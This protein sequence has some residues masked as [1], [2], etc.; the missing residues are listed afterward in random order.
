MTSLDAR[1]RA[2][3]YEIAERAAFAGN[4]DDYWR[5]AE[6]EIQDS[7]PA[8]LP[9][10]PVSPLQSNAVA[11]TFPVFPAVEA[12]SVRGLGEPL[13][14]PAREETRLFTLVGVKSIMSA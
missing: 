11:P 7:G 8:E 14:P 1:I 10:C 6:H 12:P 5:Q 3:A 9:P 13:A 2:K 4:P